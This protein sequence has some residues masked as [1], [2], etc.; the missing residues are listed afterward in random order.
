VSH[1]QIVKAMAINGL[2]FIERRLYLF[3]EF[4]GYCSESATRLWGNAE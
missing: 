3:P 4:F 1:S 2:G